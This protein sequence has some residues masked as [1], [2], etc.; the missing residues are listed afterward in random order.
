MPGNTIKFQTNIAVTVTL[1]YAKGRQNDPHPEHPEWGDSWSW[2]C[3]QNGEQKY[4]TAY[5]GLNDS[6]LNANVSAGDTVTILKKEDDNNS[7]IWDIQ[8]AG[9]PQEPSSTD[10]NSEYLSEKGN[11]ERDNW[12]R[13]LA[14]LKA[15]NPTATIQEKLYEAI[16]MERTIRNVIDKRFTD[17]EEITK[18]TLD[19]LIGQLKLPF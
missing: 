5:K 18:E 17:K 7:V 19:A 1:D 11:F 12:I 14:C 16:G 9:K 8:V 13:L 2:G 6:L 10:K 3:K 4:F 15:T